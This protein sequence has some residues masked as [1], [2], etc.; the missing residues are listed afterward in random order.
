MESIVPNGGPLERFTWV[1]M[2]AQMGA[3]SGRSHL[4]PGKAR[5]VIEKIASQI[6]PMVLTYNEVTN[7]SKCLDSLTWAQRILIVDSGSTDGTLEI[8]CRYPQVQVKHRPFEDFA[9]QC[10]FGLSQIETSWVL[11]LD[12]DY[13][14]TPKLIGELRELESGDFAA[15]QASFVYC[16]FGRSLRGTL[17]P[18]RKVLYL[19]ERA[20]YHNEG[21][22]HRVKIDGRAGHLRGKIR[23]DDHKPLRRWFSSQQ[24]YAALEADHLLSSASENLRFSDR[25]RLAGWAAPLLVFVYT[26]LVKR[27]ILDGWPGWLYVLQRTIAE[28]MI[29]LEIVDRRLRPGPSVGRQR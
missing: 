14:L 23:H 5:S 17:Y 3:L 26:L 9:S 15:Y 2:V 24:K 11:S 27:C 22:G 12:A 7:I 29:A 18:P 20:T 21:H 1:T 8:V 28:T 25:V 13:E 4:N 16:I 10:N 6:T 19:K